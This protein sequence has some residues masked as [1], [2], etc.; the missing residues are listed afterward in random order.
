MSDDVPFATPFSWDSPAMEK[1]QMLAT[2]TLRKRKFVGSGLSILM[3]EESLGRNKSKMGKLA[4]TI[5]RNLFHQHGIEMTKT[6]GFEK[7]SE[8]DANKMPG[9]GFSTNR[10]RWEIPKLG[11]TD[12]DKLHN[13]SEGKY[14]LF[15]SLLQL[16]EAGPGPVSTKQILRKLCLI[17]RPGDVPGM[18]DCKDMML[19]ALHYL[20][21][22]YATK[23]DDLLPLPLIRPSQAYGDLEKRNFVKVGDWKLVQIEA[24][25]WRMEAIFFSTPSPWKWLRREHF[26]PRGLS[27][28]DEKSFLCKGTIPLSATATKSK[29]EGKRKRRTT[30]E[31]T[32]QQ[33]KQHHQDTVSPVVAE[34]TVDDTMDAG[35]DDPVV[36]ATIVDEAT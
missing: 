6:G 10:C 5:L 3:E 1:A 18:M 32:A 29:G 33:Q 12:D 26:C 9:A 28:Q 22:N 14:S 7:Y 35:F 30:S 2:R 8:S 23:S 36:E 11:I 15:V 16:V 20:S 34:A 31:S 4:K 25:L 19:A 13:A 27:K 17:L 21:S 24:K